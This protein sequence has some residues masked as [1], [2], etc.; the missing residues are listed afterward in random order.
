MSPCPTMAAAAA[1][2]PGIKNVNNDSDERRQPVLSFPV[3]ACGQPEL[4]LCCLKSSAP[5]GHGHTHNF[6]ACSAA[7]VAARQ[8][9]SNVDDEDDVYDDAFFA[10]V[11]ALVA[12]RRGATVEPDTAAAVAGLNVAAG[13]AALMPSPAGHPGCG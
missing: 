8:G 7:A 4:H 12:S 2:G 5:Y 9:F 6:K 11:D 1:P 3:P 13:G 10:E